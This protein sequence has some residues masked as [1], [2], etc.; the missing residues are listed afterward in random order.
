MDEMLELMDEYLEMFGCT[1]PSYQL[2]HRGRDGICRIIIEC[3]RKGEDAYELGYVAS[4]K[5]GVTY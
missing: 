4:D 2:S 1:F 5:K 3:L